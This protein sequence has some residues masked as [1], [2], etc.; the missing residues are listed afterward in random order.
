MKLRMVAE[1]IVKSG[2]RSLAAALLL[3]GSVRPAPVAAADSVPSAAT[4]N[5]LVSGAV[6][7]EFKAS[8]HNLPPTD[9][10]VSATVEWNG[11]ALEYTVLRR[12]PEKPLASDR[13]T[14]HPSEDAWK[15]F[16]KDM[17]QDKIW[18]WLGSYR[19]EA[20]SKAGSTWSLAIEW[21]NK[22]VHT[23]GENRYPSMVKTSESTDSPVMFYRL[24]SALEKLVAIPLE[25]EG[26]YFTAFEASQFRPTKAP[27]QKQV[28]WVS[29]SEDFYKR[30]EK[31]SPQDS[32]GLRFGGPTVFVRARGRLAG[33]GEYGHLNGYRYEFFVEEVLEMRKLP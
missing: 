1:R 25:V 33:P 12:P 4:T 8:W 23:A 11:R 16:W 22:R 13:R 7:K 28:W 3:A 6:L 20:G 14:L 17:D 30:Y 26:E 29:G 21:A 24:H 15:E 31:L 10:V 19:G 18:D 2:G 5:E 27:Y 9:P 32:P